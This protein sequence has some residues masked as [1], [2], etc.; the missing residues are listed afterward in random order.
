MYKKEYLFCL[1][2]SVILM[3]VLSGC[4]GGQ[5]IF[6]SSRCTDSDGGL[7]YDVA[8]VTTVTDSGV[9]TTYSDYCRTNKVVGEYFCVS[10]NHYSALSSYTCSDDSICT[11]GACVTAPVFVPAVV[12][13]PVPVSN[14][15]IDECTDTDGGINF[16][17]A[18]STYIKFSS[19]QVLQGYTDTCY[20]DGSILEG[21]CV[22]KLTFGSEKAVCPSGTVCDRGVCKVSQVG[23]GCVGAGCAP[24]PSSCVDSGNDLYVVGSVSV[25]NSSGS[26]LIADSCD[27][28]GYLNEVICTPTNKGSYALYECPQGYSCSN[29]ACLAS[30]VLPVSNV[31]VDECTDTDGGIDYAQAGSTY[32]HYS[33]G[34]TL[35]GFTDSCYPDGSISE[36]YC[37]DKLSFGSQKGVC[38]SGT[39][40]SAGACRPS[41]VGVG[42]VGAG[43]APVVNSCVDSGN[44]LYVVG[45]V[46]VVNSSGTYMISDSCDV[47]GYVNEMFCTPTN[48]GSFSL[49]VCPQGYTCGNGA[50]VALTIPVSNVKLDE[51][52]DTDAGINYTKAGSTY[53]RYSSGLTL[54]GFTDT[55]YPDGSILEGYCVDKLTFGSEKAVCP[56]GTVCDRGVCK[57]SQV[58]VGCV[59]AGCAPVPSSC[60][61]SGNDLYAIGSV[62]VVN[63]SGAFMITDSCDVFGYVN[64]MFCT[65]A[66]AVSHSLGV[67]PQGYSC[68]NGAC[69][70]LP[71]PV[72]NV[73]IDE[74]TDTDGSINFN[75]AGSTYIKFSSG[76]VL[77]GFVDSCYPDGSIL[78]G[79][80]VD[81]LSFGSQKGVCPSGTVCSAGACRTAQLS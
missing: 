31:K 60:V 15:K 34:L 28:F 61:D 11:N 48:T 19:G 74:C 78:E 26:Y 70:A 80:C 42:C 3:L 66:N 79:Y 40:C 24:V 39:A 55:C 32:I 57:V 47:F 72:S 64:E 5:G 69:V 73:K 63:S 50:C 56:S 67:C 49:G 52:T 68:S 53:I 38:P 7:T 75:V 41:Q 17:L 33:T 46:S 30:P 71:V 65:P 23:V 9:K 59:G 25:V 4:S 21:Y 35:H 18:G 51:C 43:C 27:V 22:D 54:H 14:V 20:P 6:P 81:K 45:S 8:G 76:Q 10:D 29:G 62:S 36:G 37:V 13:V 2:A 16:N 44:D 12:P 58:G 1:I 77:H